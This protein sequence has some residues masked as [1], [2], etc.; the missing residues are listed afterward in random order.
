MNADEILTLRSS[1]ICINQYSYCDNS[2]A[3]HKDPNGLSPDADQKND[4]YDLDV[5]PRE[6]GGGCGCSYGIQASGNSGNNADYRYSGSSGY[7]YSSGYSGTSTSHNPYGKLGSPEHQ[8]MIKSLANQVDQSIFD[9]KY[10]VRIPTNGY[11]A[12]RYAD[13]AVYAK[14]TGDV[15]YVVQ[16]G[17][18]N[19]NGTP[20]SREQK[21]IDDLVNQG[22]I[23]VFV[24][25]RYR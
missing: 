20:V 16:V 6:L 14:G 10:E 7:S 3:A 11:K 21:A 8:E 12:I 9:V 13:F 4:E 25:Y 23:V 19:K 5:F 1:P 2:P 24:P 17:I 22:L 15:L 18:M